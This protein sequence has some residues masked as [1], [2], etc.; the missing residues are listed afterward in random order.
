MA[1]I[2]TFL[3]AVGKSYLENFRQAEVIILVRFI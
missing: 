2:L 1:F 3:Q